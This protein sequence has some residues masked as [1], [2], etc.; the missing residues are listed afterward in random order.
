[1]AT[2]KRSVGLCKHDAVLRCSYSGG[3]ACHVTWICVIVVTKFRLIPDKI[4]YLLV[5]YFAKLHKLERLCKI[6]VLIK[7]LN[8]KG[9]KYYCDLYSFAFVV[10]RKA[11]MRVV[12]KQYPVHLH[13]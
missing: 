2:C 8:S 10:T 3:C 1:V 12:L 5:D 11:N 13:S 4:K 7:G 9:L 6:A